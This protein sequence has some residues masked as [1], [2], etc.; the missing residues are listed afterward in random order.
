MKK[1]LYQIALAAFLLPILARGIFYYRGFAAR[2]SISTP[3]YAALQIA[4]AP[5]KTPA[6]EAK[7][8]AA[9]EGII[10]FDETHGNQFTPSEISALTEAIAARGGAVEFLTDSSSL[11]YK[12]KYARAFVV[13]SPSAPFYDAETRLIQN[14]TAQGGRL[15]VF[16]D[17]TRGSVYEDYISGIPKY[18]SDAPAAN[19]LLTAFDISVN[20]D[21]LYDLQ[22]NDSNF[23]NVL[24]DEF[25]KAE[26]VFGIKQAAF[27]GAHS[28]A[29]TSGTLLLQS[30]ESTRSSIDD[31]HHPQSG[32]AALSADGNTLALGDLTFLSS[33]YNKMADNAALIQN[34]A[35]F[36]L[37]GERHISLKNFP[38]V[39]E[40]PE[41]QVYL[42]SD[43]TFSTEVI[44]A[45]GEAQSAFA[46][47]GI[48]LTVG[49]KIPNEGNAIILA[50]FDQ[51]DEIAPYLKP[52]EVTLDGGE[53]FKISKFGSVGRYGSGL[54]LL[55][56]SKT[57]NTL[58]ML[59]NSSEDLVAFIGV[60]ASGSLDA[61][62]LQENFGVC[63]VG[64]GGEYGQSEEATPEPVLDSTADATPQG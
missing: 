60:I 15:L 9:M 52:F 11:E 19:T 51:N 62:V 4:P 12:L 20:D 41:A 29:T 5:L 55:Q 36:T 33:P 46:A 42:A 48:A 28:L 58:L 39:F 13:V 14:F 56:Q 17:A 44:G 22:H 27:Y 3:D 34:I 26:L 8:N 63:S 59:A 1:S 32:G 40:K 38:F 31:E 57:G 7:N 21:Y 16:T 35:D 43:V 18:Y 10:L 23:R 61:C 2:P 54:L 50:T 47:D 24:F 37:N 49:D 64:Y 25:A 30:A 6:A 53:F 45:L